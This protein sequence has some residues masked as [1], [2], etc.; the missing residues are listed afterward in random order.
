M[1]QKKWHGKKETAGAAETG[2]EY[3][4]GAAESNNR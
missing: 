4:Q 1:S 3:E 2:N